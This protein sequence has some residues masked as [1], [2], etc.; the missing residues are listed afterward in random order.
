[1]KQP[2]DTPPAGKPGTHH[3]ASEGSWECPW[4]LRPLAIDREGQKGRMKQLRGGV[5]SETLLPFEKHLLML[6]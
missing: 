6:L 4:S 1:M 5:E 2:R 3:T